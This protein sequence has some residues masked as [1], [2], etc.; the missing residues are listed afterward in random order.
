MKRAFIITL[1]LFFV[2]TA[3]CFPSVVPGQPEPIADPSIYPVKQD[4]E[5]IEASAG[6]KFHRQ[7]VRAAIKARKSGKINFREL[8]R[9]RVAMIAPAFREQAKD[10]ARIQMLSSGESDSIPRIGENIDWD[11]LFA[12]IEKLIPLILKLIDA[13][14]AVA[15]VDVGFPQVE[16]L[17]GCPPSQSLAA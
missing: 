15:S 7:V 16:F 12:F 13:I 11:E 10:L 6:D 14:T 17:S 5:V 4:V 1:A 9:I 8:T 2:V 3:M